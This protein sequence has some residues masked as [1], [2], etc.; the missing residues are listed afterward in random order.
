MVLASISEDE[1]T[2]HAGQTLPDHLIQLHCEFTAQGGMFRLGIPCDL[3][4]HT[5]LGKGSM[6]SGCSGH[7]FCLPQLDCSLPLDCV[8]FLSV[9]P[10]NLPAAPAFLLLLLAL[11]FVFQQPKECI[12]SQKFVPRRGIL[13]AT[14]PRM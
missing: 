12:L 1:C 10:V 7:G 11:V 6:D 8:S 13:Q 2:H 4:D 3:V 5:A 9:L 14:D